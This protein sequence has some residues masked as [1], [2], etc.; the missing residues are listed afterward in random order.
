MIDPSSPPATPCRFLAVA[1]SGVADIHEMPL[2]SALAV[3]ETLRA[4]GLRIVW[5][6]PETPEPERPTRRDRRTERRAARA[7]A[8]QLAELG[9]V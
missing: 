2:G 9:V 6:P 7:Q 1:P 5:Y 8:R 3:A 4:R